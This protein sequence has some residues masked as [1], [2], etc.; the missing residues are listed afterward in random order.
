VF[1]QFDYPARMPDDENLTPATAADVADAL[2]FAGSF[3][4]RKRVHNADEFMSVI[5][6]ERLVEHLERSGLVIMKKP[7][8][9]GGGALG[10][11][12]G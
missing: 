9:C 4:G 2:T 1:S 12:R 6:A 8:L 11:G 5:V 3:Q 7:P 10:R